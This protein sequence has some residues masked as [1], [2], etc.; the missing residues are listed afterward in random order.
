MWGQQKPEDPLCTERTPDEVGPTSTLSRINLFQSQ[1]YVNVNVGGTRR[2]AT[3]KSVVEIRF[4][5][6]LMRLL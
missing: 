6:A 1:N 5:A 4:H 3:R 2:N